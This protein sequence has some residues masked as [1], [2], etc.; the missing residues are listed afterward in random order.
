MNFIK[1]KLWKNLI[2]NSLSAWWRYE[3]YYII[4]V[5]IHGLSYLFLGLFISL[6]K[7]E[8]QV[9]LFSERR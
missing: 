1:L 5:I 4:G 7:S 9:M 8:Q 2:K 3:K 6:L